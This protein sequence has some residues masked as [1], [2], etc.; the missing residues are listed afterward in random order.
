MRAIKLLQRM[1]DVTDDKMGPATAKA[2]APLV[3]QHGEKEGGASAPPRRVVT[4]VL[5]Q[6]VR[7]GPDSL[8]GS[9]HSSVGC[10]HGKSAGFSWR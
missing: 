3:A 5:H 9:I 7:S 6:H 8:S 4:A 1:V 2:Y 10:R